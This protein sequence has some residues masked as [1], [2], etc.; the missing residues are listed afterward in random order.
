[1]TLRV[2]IVDDEAV[3]R[4][5]LRRMLAA[6]TGVTVVGECEDGRSALDA[7]ASTAPDLVL[8][9]VQMPER[10]G[11]DVL[12]A[13]PAAEMPAVI[14]V[15]AFDRY[16]L[17][18]FDVHAV[19]YL[20]KPFTPDRLTAAI[21]RARERIA[22]RTAASGPAA[23]AET[24]RRERRYLSRVTITSASRAVVVDLRDVDWI[25][26]EDNYVRLHTRGR[27]YLRR[28][29]LKALEQQL[30]PASFVRV[31]RSALVRIDRIAE[32]HAAGHGDG[33]LVLRDGTTVPLSRTW[34][35]RVRRALQVQPKVR[36]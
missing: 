32:I 9:D 1:M 12:R 25:A 7:I 13:I 18:A 3:A 28:G 8:L 19:D 6:E 10:D 24:L 33:N 17:R 27:H 36:G 5:R 34:R 15:T 2:L 22:S 23:L 16:A 21:G 26:A 30:D 11:F 4:R 35:E 20:L 29:T 31:H 14:F